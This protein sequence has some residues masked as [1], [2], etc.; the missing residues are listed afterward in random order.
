MTDLKIEGM[1]IAAVKKYIIIFGS[2]KTGTTQAG[3]GAAAGEIWADT[4]EE[5]SLKVGV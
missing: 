4:A 3:A 1:E 2:V 5:Y